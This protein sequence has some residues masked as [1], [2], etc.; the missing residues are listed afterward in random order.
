MTQEDFNIITD[1][2]PYLLH[3]PNRKMIETSCLHF[4]GDDAQEWWAERGGCRW[5]ESLKAGQEA[6]AK[7]HEGPFYSEPFTFE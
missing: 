7:M 1:R 4:L 2:R 6:N 3:H 5:A